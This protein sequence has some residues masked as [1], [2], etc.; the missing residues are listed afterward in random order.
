[1]Q[2]HRTAKYHQVQQG[3]AA[4][5]VCAVHGYAGNFAYREQ[6][7]DDHVFT[8][9]VHGQRLTGHFGRNTAHHVVTGWDNRNR[10]FYRVDVGEGAGQFQN[11]RQTGFQHFFTQMV[12]FQLR[13]RAPRAVAAAA[14]T[15]F[16]HDGTRHHVTTRQVFRIRGITLHKALAMFVQQIATFTTAA[17][18]HQHARTGDT[19]WVELPH[20]H[21]LHRHA[22][23]DSHPNA[24]TG[25]DVGV[26]SGLID[27]ACAAGGQHGCARFEIDHFTGFNA[28]CG[29]T[30]H[31]AIGVFHQIQRIPLGEDGGVVFQVLLIKGVQQS[32]TGTV[33]RCCGTCRLFAAEVFRLAAKRTLIDGAIFQTG[34]RQTHVVQLQNRFRAGFT[35]I[36]DGILVADVV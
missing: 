3:V 19:G 26:G 11:A 10:L 33:S 21:V 35:H 6:T 32:V 16:D 27:T 20:L 7:R 23:A 36:F 8:L 24:V 9:L 1:M 29:T 17:F 2:P 25:V 30:H 22:S 5:T 34:E 13:V 14:F 15:D 28:Q 31:R 12:E 18:C 4:Q